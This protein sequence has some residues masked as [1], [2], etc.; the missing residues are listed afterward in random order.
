MKRERAIMGDETERGVNLTSGSFQA[1]QQKRR[2][3]SLIFSSQ[4]FP[5]CNTIIFIWDKLHTGVSRRSL[6]LVPDTFPP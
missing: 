6:N 3:M 5:K 1:K 4:T 2:E